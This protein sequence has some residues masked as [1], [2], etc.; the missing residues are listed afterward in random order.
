M[1]RQ[2]NRFLIFFRAVSGIAVE[3]FATAI[4]MGVVFFLGVLILRWFS[5]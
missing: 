1:L 5:K 3:L 4:L 2:Q